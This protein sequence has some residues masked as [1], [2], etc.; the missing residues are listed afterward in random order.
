MTDLIDTV[1][2]DA[3]NDNLIE[4][5]EIKTPGAST[6]YYLFNGLDDGIDKIEF[7]QNDYLA[8]PIQIEGI[9][10]SAT[11]AAARPTLTVANIPA[12]T[13]SLENEEE[14]LEDIKEALNFDTNDDFI[15]TRVTYHRTLKSNTD[16]NNANSPEFPPQT[17]YIDRIASENNIFVAFELASPFDIEKAKLPHRVVIGKY[18]PWQYQGVKLG[19]GGGC[20]WP[21]N[22]QPFEDTNNKGLYFKS[23]DSLISRNLVGGGFSA[24]SSSTTYSATNKIFTIDTVNG[25]S[26][27]R[28]W[29]ALFTNSNKDPR[30]YNKYWKRIDLCGKTLTSCK[31][32]F[33]GNYSGTTL[34]QNVSLPFGGFPGSRKFK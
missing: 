20:T 2:D 9:E 22:N 6:S 13:K 7:R 18:C 25:H 1:Q 34:N 26:H 30:L 32:R 11:G 28:V 8:I 29:E 21:L 15:G 19:L 16:N 27:T 3:I 14:L 4:L 33:Q 12:L 31:K 24:W 5:F 10:M 23:D 17:F